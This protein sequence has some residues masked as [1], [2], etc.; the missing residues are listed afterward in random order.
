[1]FFC[2]ISVSLFLCILQPFIIIMPNA[3]ITGATQGIGKAIAEKLLKEGFSIA[4]CARTK[5]DLDTLKAEWQ[6]L[7]PHAEI[8]VRSVDMSDTHQVKHFADET[9]QAFETIDLLANNAGLFLPGKIADEAEGHLEKLMQANLLSA[10]HLTR[11]LLPRM[12]E[13]RS[14]H[15]FNICSVAS[16]K[17]YENGGSY[18]ITK[19]ALLGFSENLRYELMPDN[20]KVTA[21]MPGATWSRSWEGSGRPSERLMKAEDVAGMLWAAFSLSASANVESIIL[22]PVLGDL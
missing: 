7:Y 1:M 4:V 10:Y 3:V 9:L 13:N 14:G 15:I 8:L 16:L 18:S 6:E 2:A 20:I 5:K 22:R 21:I 12:K 17:A 11:S 19:Y